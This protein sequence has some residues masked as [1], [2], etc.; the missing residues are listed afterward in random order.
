MLSFDDDDEEEDDD[1]GDDDGDDDDD[2]D[3]DEE[4]EE[5]EEGEEGRGVGGGVGDNDDLGVQHFG[6]LS[7][8]EAVCTYTSLHLNITVNSTHDTMV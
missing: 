3:E 1:N 4:E 7:N 6:F 8:A 5:G 2:D